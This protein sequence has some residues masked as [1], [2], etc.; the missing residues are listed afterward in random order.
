MLVPSPA[1]RERGPESSCPHRQGR[2]ALYNFVVFSSFFSRLPPF[3]LPL[4]LINLTGHMALSGGR[5]TGSLYILQTG[6][7]EYLVGVFMALFSII[8]VLTALSI[9][10]WVDRV[11]AARVMRLGIGLVLVGAWMPVIYLS[12]LT[13]LMMALTI[14]FGFNVLSVASQHTVGHLVANA[15]PSERLANFGWFALGH[16]ASSAFGPFIAGL[17][18]DALVFREAFAALALFACAAA[19]LV[20]TR[21][22]D[23]PRPNAAPDIDGAV[24]DDDEPREVPEKPR[25]FDLL[26]T[27]EM[28]R[29]YW[30]NMIMSASWDLFIVMLPVLGHRLGYSASVIGSV[31]SLFAVGT[32]AARAAMPWLSRRANEWQIL[33]VSLAVV[34]LVFLA[35]PWAGV[36]PALMALGLLF[37]SA[38]GMS[39]PNMLS[40]LH[41]ASPAGRGGEA[42]GL[43]SVLSNS[44][45][46]A[47]PLAFGAAVVPF[48]ISALLVS[49]GVLFASGIPFAHQGA[50]ARL[51]NASA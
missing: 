13:L 7:A 25:V 50:R 30:V 41:A 29:I 46:V 14:G 39:Q 48:G 21:A 19:W 51:G 2:I 27:P 31:F 42:V 43:R 11:G 23:L 3:L 28:R 10:R 22:R 49:G 8:S 26:A 47:V 24:T 32:F 44:C 17:L 5:V 1:L 9:G 40:L 36:A 20:V 35:L 6:N 33:R 15:T 34:T 12:L 4:I 16:S 45:S 37:G 38:V 18:I